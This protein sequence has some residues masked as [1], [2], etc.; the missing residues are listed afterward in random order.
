[1]PRELKPETCCVSHESYCLRSLEEKCFF[2]FMSKIVASVP[3]RGV[4]GEKT[5][6]RK[7]RDT[8]L[9]KAHCDSEM[10]VQIKRLDKKKKEESLTT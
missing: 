4:E 6:F 2:W 8:S 5:L 9:C 7:L 1:M 10:N 3:K